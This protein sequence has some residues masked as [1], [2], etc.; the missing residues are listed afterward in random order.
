MRNHFV[1]KLG[2]KQTDRFPLVTF[3]QLLPILVG[4]KGKGRDISG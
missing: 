3:A 1:D 4:A 2:V